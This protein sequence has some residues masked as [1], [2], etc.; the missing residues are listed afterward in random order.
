MDTCP[1]LKTDIDH[2]KDETSIYKKNLWLIKIR[3]IYVVFLTLYFLVN[4]LLINNSTISF[5]EALLILLLSIIGNLIFI[6]GI[7]NKEKN[8]NYY[9]Q[10]SLIQLDFDLVILTFLV[11]FSGGLESQISILYI[12]FI[13]IS[14]FIIDSKKALRNTITAIILISVVFTL[15]NEFSKTNLTHLFGFN[16]ILIFTYFISSF[17]SSNIDRSQFLLKELLKKTKE[18]SITDDLTGLYNQ[19]QFFTLLDIELKRAERYGNN[20]SIIIFD[21]DNFKNYNDNNGHLKGS[22]TLR[23]IG[24][25]MK[26]VFRN[27]DILARYGG[28]EFILILPDTDS[29]GAYLAAERIREAVEKERFDGEEKQPLGKITIT[30]GIASFPEHGK[31]AKDIIDNADKALYVAKESG[32]NRSVIYT[33]KIFNKED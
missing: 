11:F 21:V 1:D 31:I 16:I 29:V 26:R 27:G 8:N 10:L 17:L 2:A 7:I 24:K 30:L 13:M 20:L 22:D 15:N 18:L 6:L 4:K 25:I 32:R 19:A 9:F 14:S 3:W 23:K 5:R 28:D 33:E 12:F